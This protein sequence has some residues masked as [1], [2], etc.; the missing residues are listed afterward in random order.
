MEL[1]KQ[2]IGTDIIEIGRIEKAI[3]RW[4]ERFLNRLCTDNE[5]LIY[6]GN[7]PSL[8]ALFAGKEAIIKTLE[9]EQRRI[10]WREIEIL[11]KSG[12]KPYVNLYGEAKIR[13]E[14]LGLRNI[15]ISLSHSRDY[16]IAFA[17]G[18]VA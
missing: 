11:T 12:G 9:P 17:S 4:G 6:H 5:L 1:M 10:G 14:Y 8:A 13:S 2:I 3:N 15:S 16:A 7:L 18:I